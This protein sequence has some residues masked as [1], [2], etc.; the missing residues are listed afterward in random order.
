MAKEK[1]VLIAEIVKKKGGD[2]YSVSGFW[3][4]TR[5][6]QRKTLTQS[7]PEQLQRQWKKLMVKEGFRP[8]PGVVDPDYDINISEDDE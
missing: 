6:K 2:S 4:S 8:P 3:S 5:E 7:Q 1:W